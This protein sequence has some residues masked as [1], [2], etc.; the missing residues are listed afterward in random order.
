MYPVTLHGEGVGC[1]ILTVFNKM[2]LL[3]T[4]EGEEVVIQGWVLP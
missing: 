3:E 1:C 4:A 2:Q